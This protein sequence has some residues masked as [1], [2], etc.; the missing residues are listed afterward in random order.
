MKGQRINCMDINFYI[1][2][3]HTKDNSKLAV[4]S[5]IV[6]NRHVESKIKTMYPSNDKRSQC[7]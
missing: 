6:R 2:S 5:N 7:N 4:A 3:R 1:L